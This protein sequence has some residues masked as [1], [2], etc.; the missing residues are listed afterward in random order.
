MN[1]ASSWEDSRVKSAT[2]S[3]RGSGK[4]EVWDGLWQ[5]HNTG[6]LAETL[7]SPVLKRGV[8]KML[9]WAKMTGVGGK[10]AVRMC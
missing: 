4:G 5:S 10:D 9:P 7:S 3:G 8:A 1:I 6:G 2:R